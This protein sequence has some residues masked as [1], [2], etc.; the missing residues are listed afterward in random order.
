[1]DQGRMALRQSVTRQAVARQ[2]PGPQV[3]HQDVGR[4]EQSMEQ[5]DLRHIG[6]VED[7]RLLAAVEGG[8][9]AAERHAVHLCEG[10]VAAAGITRGPLHLH[11]LGTRVREDL[12][13][14]RAGDVL[15]QRDDPDPCERPGQGRVHGAAGPTGSSEK[16]PCRT[17]ASTALRALAFR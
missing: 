4:V 13:A 9:A 7:D 16:K 6:Q 5:L 2:R 14:Q 17:R 12:G 10:G 1:M 11:D 15:L 8:E 3:G